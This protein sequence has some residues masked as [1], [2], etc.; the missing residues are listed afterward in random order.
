MRDSRKD[1]PMITHLA[2]V[3][4]FNRS[5]FFVG[6]CSGQDAEEA[7]YQLGNERTQVSFTYSA[8]GCVRDSGGDVFVWVKDLGKASIV[9]HELAHAA[10]SIMETC[11]IPQCRET[12]EVMCYL[13]G[14]LKL[15]V[16]DK[17]YGKFEKKRKKRS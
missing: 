2:N 4:I 11:G 8:S 15:H 7:V 13:I 6:D 16:Q 1:K 17:V 12:E 10:C 14:W 9:A 3:P 5:V